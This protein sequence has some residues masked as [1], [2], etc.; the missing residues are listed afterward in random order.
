MCRKFYETMGDF[1]AAVDR[2]DDAAVRRFLEEENADANAADGG[3]PAIVRAA[4]GGHAATV[5]VLLEHRADLEAKNPQGY[6]ALNK[7]VDEGHTE[8]ARVL[9]KAGADANAVARGW[10]AI[11]IAASKGH[12]A[13]VGVL[14]EH[15][16][17]LE[18]K[19]NDGMTALIF[20]AQN[21]LADFSS[22]D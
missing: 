17:D 7:A 12:A 21:D 5:G 14:I 18:A 11:V 15:R 16:A 22:R 4:H 6:T 3:W 13:T 9:L 1:I 19:D 8:T 2:G 10:P 20:A